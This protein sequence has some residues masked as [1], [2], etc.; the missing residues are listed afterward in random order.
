MTR[1]LVVPQ[2]QG[3]PSSRAMQLIDG[4][5]AIAGDLPRPRTT[6]LEIPMEAGESQGSG[7]HRLS[8]LQ[9]VRGLIEEALAEHTEPV[10]TVGGDC[11]IALAPI[12][13]AARGHDNLAVVWVDAHPDFNTP[14]TSPSGAFSGMVLRA[15]L[16][17]GVP[18]LSL[19]E[20]TLSAERV[21]LVATRSYDDPELEA[22]RAR[23]V[24]VVTADAMA[25]PQ[26]LAAAVRAT[27]ATA[28]YLHVDVDALDP[29]ELAGNAHPEPFG[30]RVAELTAAIAA[31]RAEVPLVGASLTGYS[32][33]SAEAATD[34]LGA[35]LRIV[36][37]LA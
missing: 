36:G 3:S 24:A 19:E 9:R 18:G 2:W 16:G 12:A 21:V 37:A 33:A 11:G 23:G 32:P 29:A 27:G 20:G 35:L 26:A 13:H 7:I 8:T 1:Y 31:L 28:V 30:V 5:R 34:D 14:E 22:V 6:I 25:D 17:E 10:L 4:A 15:A